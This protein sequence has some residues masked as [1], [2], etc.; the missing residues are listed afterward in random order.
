MTS[1][2][3]PPKQQFI[4]EMSK[5]LHNTHA[6]WENVDI[7]SLISPLKIG[8]SWVQHFL[9]RHPEL[10]TV[11][12]CTIE[13]S[14]LKETSKEAINSWFDELMEVIREH[15]IEVENMYN[16]DETG[17][18]IGN[19]QGAY[20]VVNKELQTK[21]QVH[22]GRQEWVTALECVCVDGGKIPPL[23]I[24]KG[25]SLSS[26]WIPKEALEM[27]DYYFGCSDRGWTNNDLGLKWLKNC[28]E[29]TTHEKVGGRM[30]M[31]IC[32]GHES[33]ISADFSAFCM[34]H[35]IILF[36][37]IPHSSHLLQPL[38]VG[39]FGPL[40]KVVSSH[41]SWL[42]HCGIIR[43]EKIE[44]VENYIEVREVAITAENI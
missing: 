9:H 37:L 18:S 6:Q 13:S 34:D 35:D 10:K 28:F 21:Y 32:D 29:P 15:Q 5:H 25:K 22:P 1:T 41:L 31:L 36:L 2:G 26:S 40:K 11:I 43:L 44:W 39:V 7:S 27:K 42:L 12:S 23:I 30:R 19:I 14:R 17:F 16:M 33:H 4:Q 20:V 8:D 38:N 3:N 24:L